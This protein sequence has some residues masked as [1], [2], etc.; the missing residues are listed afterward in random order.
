MPPSIAVDVPSAA[1]MARACARERV[2]ERVAVDRVDVAEVDVAAR[3]LGHGV[4]AGAAR[5]QADVDGDAAVPV[6]LALG[7]VDEARQRPQR[8]APVLEVVAGVGGLAGDRDQHLAG[9]LALRDDLIG[10]A[11]RLEHQRGAGARASS[12]SSGR[13][14]FEPVSSSATE[15]SASGRSA[16]APTSASAASAVR[17][18]ASPPFMSST[19]GPRSRSPARS[20]TS[21]VPGGNTVSWWPIS[22]T[23]A[24]GGAAANAGVV[25]TR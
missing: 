10:R 4:G 3:V 14:W 16:S 9:A 5:R 17:M 24:A 15:H 2:H 23:R 13:E 25:H 11:A 20:H 8:V 18:V 12:S 21:K 1:S 19:P 7:E 6:G 22:T